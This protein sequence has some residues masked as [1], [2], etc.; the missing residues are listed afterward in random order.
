MLNRQSTFPTDALNSSQ[1]IQ[2]SDVLTQLITDF[3]PNYED[4]RLTGKGAAPMSRRRQI[5]IELNL[6]GRGK[7]KDE[8]DPNFF[9]DA[10]TDD[11]I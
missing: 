11:Q 4:K 9:V 3:N 5:E 6:N 8:V 1:I 2:M 7:E 10:Y